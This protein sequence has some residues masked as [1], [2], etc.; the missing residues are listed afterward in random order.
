MYR[1]YDI[2]ADSRDKEA[3]VQKQKEI[4][5]SQ[6][7]QAEKALEEFKLQVEKN[8]TRIYTETK[9]QV[10]IMFWDEKESGV[11]VVLSDVVINFYYC[12]SLV[13]YS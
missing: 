6:L 11:S 9:Q 7:Q 1:D 12:L 4:G 8:Q 10:S 5:R 2:L 3:E 13:K